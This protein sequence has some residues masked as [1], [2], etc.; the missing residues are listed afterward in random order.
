MA[1]STTTSH[2]YAVSQLTAATS[3]GGGQK[4]QSPLSLPMTF[5][6]Q[7]H[8]QAIPSSA[9]A[10]AVAAAAQLAAA[11][12][13]AAPPP[14]NLPTV[15]TSSPQPPP[16][17]ISQQQ[18]QQPPLAPLPSWAYAENWRQFQQAA[19]NY[20]LDPQM[21]AAMYGS[22]GGGGG[23]PPPVIGGGGGFGFGGQHPL[24]PHHPQHHHHHHHRGDLSA[25]R[26]NATRETT[27]ILKAWLNEHKKNPYPTKGEKIMLAIITTMTLTQVS[28]W[29]ANAR[30][31]LKKENKMTWSTPTNKAA[32]AAA[33]NGEDGLAAKVAKPRIWSIQQ[34]QVGSCGRRL[35]ISESSRIWRRQPRA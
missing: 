11:A 6:N 15:P 10:A 19:Y 5:L 2:G 29:F 13:M 34:Q 31:R 16:P 21:L 20:N 24:H 32:T 28:T 4:T 25:R 3:P 26:K 22:G 23:G 14:P 18:Q 17:P 1:T 7:H 33:T 30:R 35:I 12:Q 9:A 8:M 27:S